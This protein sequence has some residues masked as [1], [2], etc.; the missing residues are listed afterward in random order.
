MKGFKQFLFRGNVIDL[1]IAVVIGAAFGTVVTAFVQDLLTPLVGAIFA[2][3]DFSSLVFTVNGSRFMYGHFANALISFLMIATAVYYFLVVP[4][5]TLK[6]RAAKGE[7]L[8]DPTL[9]SC[10]ECL[11]EIPLLARRCGHCTAQLT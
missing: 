3:P 9:R 11:M 1:A 10:P 8:P 4:I 5:N 2:A 7:A 6:A